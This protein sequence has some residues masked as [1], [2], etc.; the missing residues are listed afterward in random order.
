MVASWSSFSPESAQSSQSPSRSAS[1]AAAI[2]AAEEAGASSSHPKRSPKSLPK[3]PCAQRAG[4]LGEQDTGAGVARAVGIFGLGWRG[5]GASMSCS[6]WGW[7]VLANTTAQRLAAGWVLVQQ[8]CEGGA[9]VY[10]AEGVKRSCVCSF[11][12]CPR[13]RTRHCSIFHVCH[14][15]ALVAPVASHPFYRVFG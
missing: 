8:M 10:T 12:C 5:R 15:F 6:P 3:G 14:A 13:H 7:D 1:S 9:T 2:T 4:A 11:T